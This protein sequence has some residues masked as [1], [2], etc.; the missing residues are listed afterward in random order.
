MCIYSIIGGLQV[1][2][3]MKTFKNLVNGLRDYNSVQDLVKDNMLAMDKRSYG[4]G[5]DTNSANQMRQL[6][7]LR[8][9]NKGKLT[10]KKRMSI[11]NSWDHIKI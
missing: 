8:K 6:V 3:K 7:Q 10:N 5:V 2:S 1:G 11:I 9:L 4:Y